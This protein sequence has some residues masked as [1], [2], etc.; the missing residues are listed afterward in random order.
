MKLERHKCWKCLK[1]R[2]GKWFQISKNVEIWQCFQCGNN[3]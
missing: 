3:K 1:R 2:I